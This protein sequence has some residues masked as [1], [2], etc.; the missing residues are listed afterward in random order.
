MWKYHTST[1]SRAKLFPGG[2]I[3]LLVNTSK[4]SGSSYFQVNNYWVVLFSGEYLLTV[5]PVPSGM[6]TNTYT[7]H[8]NI[9]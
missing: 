7:S 9:F 6:V 5:T 4:Y 2:S 1:I 3:I 8:S